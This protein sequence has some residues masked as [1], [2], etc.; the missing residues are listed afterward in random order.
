Q[1]FQ[2]SPDLLYYHGLALAHLERWQDARK[3]LQAGR[4]MRPRDNRFPIELAGIAFKQKKYPECAAYLRAALHRDPTDAYVIDFLAT[5][6]SLEDNRA[7]AN[8]YWTV[9]GTPAIE[10]V[11]TPSG[12]HV[13]PVLLDHVF[14]FSP[15]SILRLDELLATEARLK[16]LQIF[17][18][19]R[20]DLL[21]RD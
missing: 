7:A 12:L 1:S 21:A 14:A 3:V 16:T 11:R 2:P 6:H 19:Y 5:F 13:D 10:D 4:R 20:L 15:A 8:K 18:S 17:P 9:E